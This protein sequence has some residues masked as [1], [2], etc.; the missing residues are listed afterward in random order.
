[1]TDK[2]KKA[3][4]NELQQSGYD[5]G[6]GFDEEEGSIQF[7][8]IIM[9]FCL[10]PAVT[11]QTQLAIIILELSPHLASKYCTNTFPMCVGN[12]PCA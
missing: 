11:N 2:E 3:F 6:T 12:D 7:I 1:M 5:E 9:I 4:L 10:T 8:K